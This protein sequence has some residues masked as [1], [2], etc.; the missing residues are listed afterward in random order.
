M[1]GETEYT[2]SLGLTVWSVKTICRLMMSA[3]EMG[4]LPLSTFIGM[5]SVHDRGERGW[6]A[7]SNMRTDLV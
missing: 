1:L 4:S 6:D 2:V 5:G 7:S 3:R